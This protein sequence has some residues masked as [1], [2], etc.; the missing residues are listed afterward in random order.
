MVSGSWSLLLGSSGDIPHADLAAFCCV[1]I[2]CLTIC[3]GIWQRLLLGLRK[4]PL[5]I[6]LQGMTSPLALLIVWLLLTSQDEALKSFL[7]LGSFI[8]TA[9]VAIAGFVTAAIMTRPILGRAVR[10]LWRPRRYPGARVMDVGLPMLAQMLTNPISV[11]VPRYVLAILSTP[12]AVAQYALAGQVFFAVQALIAAAGV[13][14]WPQ[15]ARARSAGKIKR[16]PYLLSL[17]FGTSV[18]FVTIVLLYVG[19]QLFGFISDGQ[20]AIGNDLIIGFGI[21]MAMQALLY[22]LGMFIM[23]K[24]GIR[25]QVIPSLLMAVSTVVLTLALVPSWGVLGPVTANAL[26]VLVFQVIPYSIYI[27]RNRARL[28]GLTADE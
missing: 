5:I 4:N 12:V 11:A 9:L 20:L 6:L 25:F 14:L 18:A 22:P 27:R 7:A 10:R 1:L 28:Y 3:L 8:A 16:G 15:F 17:L 2:Y 21:M 13:A 23:D 19:P 26:S 24:P